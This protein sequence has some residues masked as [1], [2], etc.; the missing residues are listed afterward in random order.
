M[1]ALDLET[2]SNRYFCYVHNLIKQKLKKTLVPF[3]LNCAF[4][5]LMIELKRYESWSKASAIN[6][7]INGGLQ[8]TI[9]SCVLSLI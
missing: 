1:G 4:V 3:E 7:S 5:S 9:S 6:N 8:C 2:K